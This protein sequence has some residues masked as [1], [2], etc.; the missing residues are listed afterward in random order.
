MGWIFE[1][2]RPVIA[3]GI[4]YLLNALIVVIS[5]WTEG[6]H[7]FGLD[8]TISRYVGLRHWSAYLNMVIAVVMVTL[9][10]IYLKKSKM[11]TVRKAL[12]GA[13]YK[14]WTGQAAFLICG[15]E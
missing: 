9:I 5:A 13:V 2:N 12:Y 1:K 14:H 11:H 8:L 7:R 4:I 3:A 15:S 10:L 6:L